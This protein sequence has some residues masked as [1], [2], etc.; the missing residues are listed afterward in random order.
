[1]SCLQLLWVP[2]C[3]VR[4]TM[5]NKHE[6]VTCKLEAH[7]ISATLCGAPPIALLPRKGT[8]SHTFL[9]LVILSFS[10]RTFFVT[11]SFKS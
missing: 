4:E 2:G 3:E 8:K 10:H 11:C 9:H 7:L 6:R 1:M 5:G